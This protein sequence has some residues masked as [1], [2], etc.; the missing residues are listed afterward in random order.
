MIMT[1]LEYEL[2]RDTIELAYAQKLIEHDNQLREIATRNADLKMQR[3]QN[4]KEQYRISALRD[5]LV[6]Q[7]DQ[8]LLELEREY[9]GKQTK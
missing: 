8:E 6:F 2:E 3:V 4:E 1:E 5:Q 7:R 9:V